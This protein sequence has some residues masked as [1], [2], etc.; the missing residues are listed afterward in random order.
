MGHGPEPVPAPAEV[1]EP[2]PAR[3]VEPDPA[4]P[5]DP[6]LRPLEKGPQYGGLTYDCKLMQYEGPI[7]F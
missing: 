6:A 5:G 7:Q 2:V 4:F 1:P 3:A